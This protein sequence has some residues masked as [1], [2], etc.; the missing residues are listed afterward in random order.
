MTITN[1]SSGNKCWSAISVEDK[2][3][4]EVTCVPDTVNC[5]DLN[6][7]QP[8][9]NDAL[10]GPAFPMIEG[11]PKYTEANIANTYIV[12]TDNECQ[13]SIAS[14]IDEL[15]DECQGPF[16]HVIDRL[17]TFEDPSGNSET[18]IQRIYVRS[19]DVALID[20]FVRFEADCL[21]DFT[22][23]DE[24]GYPLP[25]ETGYPTI[26]SNHDANVCGNLK[27][28][29]DDTPFSLCGRSIK[30]AR[31]WTILDWCTDEVRYLDQII[32]IEDRT[33]PVFTE[34]LEDFGIESDAF[35]CGQI[36]IEIPEPT[37]ED[38]DE[39][40]TW[41][42][43]YETITPEGN[44]ILKDNGSSLIIPEILMME[45]VA[46]F[47]VVY[48]LT[49]ACGNMSSDTLVLT[50]EDKEVPVAVCNTATTISVSGNGEAQ[51]RA[52]TF[53]DLSV[54]NC[55]I[56]SYMVRKLDGECYVRDEFAETIKFCCEEVG[57]TMHVEF[58]VEDW[59]GNTNTCLVS[60]YVQ[61]KFKP[62]ITCPDSVFLDCD[63]D[64]NDFVLTG[65]PTY[66]DNCDGME[67][68]N[69][70]EEFLNSC[71][72]GYIKRQWIVTDRGEFEAICV[73]II[74]IEEDN[75]FGL[76]DTEF[77][78]HVTLNGCTGSLEPAFTGSPILTPQ[79]CANVDA[80]HEDQY[81]YN[82]ED[83]CYKIIREWTIVDWCQL[84]DQNADAGFWT[85]VQIIK[86]N[87]ELGPIITLPIAYV[88]KILVVQHP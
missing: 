32:Q 79:G 60:V 57:D 15:V 43:Y 48:V 76:A 18:C 5:Y 83:A 35:I 22:E 85:N 73:Q 47:D 51:V 37:F 84:D 68:I 36:N 50:I 38:C 19:A 31:R 56:S 72:E 20:N 29:Y 2:Y 42:I 59:A 30:L 64:F 34:S 61:D 21:E 70:D 63:Q 65:M 8:T 1:P 24:N 69:V 67:L 39:D 14:Y 74:I 54:D 66:R 78:A 33:P 26:N 3:I 13:I 41:Q 16:K 28:S 45:I 52:L 11:N 58:Q 75:K 87:S 71:G 80:S 55:G 10:G 49:D 88:S 7:L 53:D 86:V 12:E 27:M 17:W 4:S 44:R 6:H 9:A 62:Q 40:I 25:S 23:V 82:V 81:F 46:S 77:P